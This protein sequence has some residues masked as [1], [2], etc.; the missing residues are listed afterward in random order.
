MLPRANETVWLTHHEKYLCLYYVTNVYI[1][2]SISL[3]PAVAISEEPV[4]LTCQMFNTDKDAT[5]KRQSLSAPSE[6]CLV[7]DA[8]I[9]NY[10]NIILVAA[11]FVPEASYQRLVRVLGRALIVNSSA[12]SLRNTV[13]YLTETVRYT[14]WFLVEGNITH[15]PSHS[16]TIDLTA[17]LMARM[18]NLI[19]NDKLNPD[20]LSCALDQSSAWYLANSEDN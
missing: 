1:H 5:T 8:T 14:R 12:P 9:I 13:Q 16:F 3:S 20:I 19:R 17:V 6:R 10:S 18:Y 11:S 4:S 2:S 7:F 15:I